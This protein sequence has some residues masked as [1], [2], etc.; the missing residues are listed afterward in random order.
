MIGSELPLVVEL[1]EG[2]V[3]LVRAVGPVRDQ[4]ARATHRVEL[5]RLDPEARGEPGGGEGIF[6]DPCGQGWEP[7][8]P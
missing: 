2:V 8:R 6:G 4:L 7:T 5:E 3:V 1:P